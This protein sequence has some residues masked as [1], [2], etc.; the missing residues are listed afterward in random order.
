MELNGKEYFKFM[1]VNFKEIFLVIELCKCIQENSK[2]NFPRVIAFCRYW[3]S[4]SSKKQNNVSKELEIFFED[5]QYKYKQKKTKTSAFIIL[6]KWEAREKLLLIVLPFQVYPFESAWK[7]TYSVPNTSIF[8][9]VCREMKNY[10]TL[11]P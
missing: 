6:A 8:I 7:K 10:T 2:W 5:M 3:Q 9:V 4:F 1:H 11:H